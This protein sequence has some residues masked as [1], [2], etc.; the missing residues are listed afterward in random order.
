MIYG[1]NYSFIKC[2]NAKFHCNL[3]SYKRAADAWKSGAMS[4]ECVG[5]TIKTRKG[6]EQILED[7]E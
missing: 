6:E 2:T 1:I 3:R 7:E 4:K 5:V